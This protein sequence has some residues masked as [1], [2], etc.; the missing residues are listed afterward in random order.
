MVHLLVNAH[1]T[2]SE[3]FLPR[4]L[5]IFSSLAV[6]IPSGQG[7]VRDLGC[8]D[9]ARTCWFVTISESQSEVASL[10]IALGHGFIPWCC[11]RQCPL[12]GAH[13]SPAHRLRFMAPSSSGVSRV[14]EKP[15]SVRISLAGQAQ[16]YNFSAASISPAKWWIGRSDTFL[17]IC[18]IAS[19]QSGSFSTLWPSKIFWEVFKRAPGKV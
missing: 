6:G 15:R 1:Q 17:E 9:K 5:R 2:T 3:Q 14:R 13:R 19:S 11:K 4:R 10:N 18:L 8:T 12:T 16:R 7:P